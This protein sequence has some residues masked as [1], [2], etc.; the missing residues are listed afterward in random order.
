MSATQKLDSSFRQ[1]AKLN[2]ALDVVIFQTNENKTHHSIYV[3]APGI[4]GGNVKIRVYETINF[5]FDNK[6]ETFPIIT[7]YSSTGNITYEK[8]TG[9]FT[10]SSGEGFKIITN[11][12]YINS[13][14]VEY[15]DES[16]NKNETI[17][18]AYQGVK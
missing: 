18:V 14:Y 17:Y 4:T 5:F 15:L 10:I 16:I 6:N 7:N 3:K 8:K 13:I 11:S 9:I 12:S 1:L 2:S